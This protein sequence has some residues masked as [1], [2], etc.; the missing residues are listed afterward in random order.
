MQVY[1]YSIET[2]QPPI[3]DSNGPR[4]Q[5]L[6]GCSPSRYLCCSNQSIDN[7]LAWCR[8]NNLEVVGCEEDLPMWRRYAF[9]QQTVDPA[10]YNNQH[11]ATCCYGEA[12]PY[13]LAPL[14]F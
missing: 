11:Q 1:F 4:P 2:D 5:P 7:I 13:G 3:L 12:E 9:T 14:H 8:N 10:L 6:E